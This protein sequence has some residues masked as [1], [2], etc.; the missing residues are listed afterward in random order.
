MQKAQLGEGV[1]GRARKAHPS[2]D[3]A[4]AQYGT[5]H[6]YGQYRE[7]NTWVYITS[8]LTHGRAVPRWYT[9]HELS[10]IELVPEL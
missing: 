7:G 4:L 8:G 3:S 1:S 9:R 6:P 5:S 2:R 10:I